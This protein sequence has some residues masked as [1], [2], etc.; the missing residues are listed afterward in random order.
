MVVT[1]KEM[2]NHP[3]VVGTESEKNDQTQDR[4][5]IAYIGSPISLEIDIYDRKMQYEDRYDGC[6]R[7]CIDCSTVGSTW[8]TKVQELIWISEKILP[9]DPAGDRE[10]DYQNFQKPE[11]AILRT[12]NTPVKEEMSSDQDEVE[13]AEGSKK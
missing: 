6:S 8:T 4:L 9:D 1:E 10:Q 3:K 2:V 13:S 11:R 5:I 7:Y 12:Q